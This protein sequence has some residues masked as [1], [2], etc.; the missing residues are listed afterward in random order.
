MKKMNLF[1]LAW[2]IFI[3]TALF[4]LLGLVD[5][6]I[7][8][9]YDD[10]AASSVSTA[11]QTVSIM[12]IIFNIFSTASAVMISQHL[13]AKQRRDASQ[14]AALS[15]VLQLFFGVIVSAVYLLFNRQLL[16]LIG[17]EGQL[18]DYACR[19]LSIVGGSLF[20]QALM[21]AISVIIRNHGMTKITMYVS[22]GMNL[23]NTAMDLALVPRMGVE[24]AAIATAVSRAIGCFVLIWILFTK[25][26]KPSIFKLLRPFPLRQLR[27]MLKIGV[28]SAMETFLYNLSQLVITSIVLIYL[29][30]NELVAKTYVQSVTMFFYLF[31]VSIGQASQILIGHLV[32]AEE[33]EEAY[34]QCY[35]SHRWALL[36]TLVS[37]AIGVLLRYQLAGLFTDNPEVI[38]MC[39]DILLL[40]C[41]LELGRTTNHVVIAC[42]RGAGDVYYPTACAII[43]NWAL[44]VFGSYLLAVVF[45]MGLYGMW[46]ALAADECFR[47]VLMLLRWRSNKWREKRLVRANAA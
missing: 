13:G 9:G 27:A 40:N 31:A 4:M 14:V 10:L 47:G 6:F 23:F 8:S 26:E 18:L 19:Y 22:V 12:T 34:R 25:V 44:S 2:P 33:Y 7:L 37:C 39:S 46:I 3:E 21:G 11:N 24:G 41:V 29:S 28:P 30:E 45:D 38:A 32:G 36:I 1:S 20:L 5:V 42:M 17:A 16:I 15:I 43:S 35:R